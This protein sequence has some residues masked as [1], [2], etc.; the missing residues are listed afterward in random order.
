MELGVKK[1]RSGMFELRDNQLG[2]VC[3]PDAPSRESGNILKVIERRTGRTLDR[4]LE[5]MSGVIGG[6][7]PQN[8]Y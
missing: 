7:S 2:T 1:P 5:R 4:I 8:R 6:L 3:L